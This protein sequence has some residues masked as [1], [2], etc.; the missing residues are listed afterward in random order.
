MPLSV[1]QAPP[2]IPTTQYRDSRVDLSKQTISTDAVVPPEDE[3]KWNTLDMASPGQSRKS[4]G[5]VSGRS[6]WNIEEGGPKGRRGTKIPKALLDPRVQKKLAAKKES[7]PVFM[8]SVTAVN[9]FLL[10]YAIVQY[11]G[12][13]SISDNP[14]LGPGSV[15]LVVSGAKY[16]PCMVR[17]STIPGGTAVECPTGYYGPRMA[18]GSCDYYVFLDFYCGM[19][20]FVGYYPDQW[21][22]FLTPMFLHV[23]VF[24]LM[25]NLMFQIFSGFD[26]EREIGTI[27]IMIIYILSGAAG[28]IFGALMAPLACMY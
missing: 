6:D 25:M 24:H 11:G 27:R 7:L 17:N 1:Q 18:N 9:V 16:T 2:V 19:G 10:M 26:M 4:L 12:F 15:A 5:G 23:G 14:L 3:E 8:I 13:D 20:G 28:N 22:R 21:F